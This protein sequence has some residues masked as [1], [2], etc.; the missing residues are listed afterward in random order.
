MELFGN[1]ADG[2]KMFAEM[3]WFL[4]EKKNPTNQ[5]STKQQTKQTQIPRNEMFAFIVVELYISVF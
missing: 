5:K 3:F 2:K 1:K 4:S